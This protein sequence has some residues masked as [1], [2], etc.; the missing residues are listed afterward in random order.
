VGENLEKHTSWTEEEHQALLQLQEQGLSY[1]EMT[2]QMTNQFKIEF[3][4]NSVRNKLRRTKK[5]KIEYADRKNIGNSIEDYLLHLIQH[6][7]ELQKF[8]DRQTSVTLDIKDDKPIGI[9]FSGDWHVGG[10]YTAH[11]EMLDDFKMISETDGLYN[12][13]MGDYADNYNS[14][15]HKGGWI[16]Q[17]DNPDKQ[18]DIIE[19]LFTTYLGKSNIAVLKGNHDN[20]ETRETS[21]D[22]VKHVA[23]LIESPY[24]WYGGEINLR[25]GNQVYR[26]IAR[27]TYMGNSALNTTNSQR[28]LFDETQGDVIA[29]GHLHYNEVH[30]KSKAGKD[31]V[32]I[33]T[34]TYKRTDDYT[35]WVIGGSGRGDIRQPMI[36]LFPGTKKI[37]DFRD[38]YDGIKYLNM[39]RQ[40]VTV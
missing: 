29:L 15:S 4:W 30:S 35:Q 1:R 9:V 28:R 20:W 31:T 17:I 8:D 16:E 33:R 23:R 3:T 37:L 39:L 36:I 18:K 7:E 2:N 12:I 6:Q 25:L 34:G 11:K 32:W 27:H 5:N 19:H 22:F 21:E 14:G 26:V 40:G 24:L 38:M 13:T 10:L